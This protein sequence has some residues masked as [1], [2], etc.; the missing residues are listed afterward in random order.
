MLAHQWWAVV[1]VGA[2]W[3]HRC[4]GGRF[5]GVIVCTI[6]ILGHRCIG[7]VQ[8]SIIMWC[9]SN[10]QCH[11][12]SFGCH[13]AISDVAPGFWVNREMERGVLGSPGGKPLWMVMMS[14][15]ITVV[16]HCHRCCCVDV[17]DASFLA[18]VGD[19]AF[20]HH[21]NGVG[22]WWG[23]TKVVGGRGQW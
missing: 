21:S 3:G 14:C 6:I 11:C 10:D 8:S 1:A 20:P 12:L 17:A 5:V 22:V 23:L 16:L 19:V 4:P 7:V 18:M 15:V 2:W 9:L 13:I